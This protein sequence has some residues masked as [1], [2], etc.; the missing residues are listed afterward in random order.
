MPKGH[1]RCPECHG[2][3]G[4]MAMVVGG[5]SRWQRCRCV[6]GGISE[7]S[8]MQSMFKVQEV[9]EQGA[10]RT[11]LKLAIDIAQYCGITEIQM[12]NYLVNHL[13]YKVY[14]DGNISALIH[15]MYKENEN[16]GQPVAKG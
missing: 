4:K 14:T 7:D 9:I 6:K 10:D 16:N 5:K 15:D 8:K 12:V 11:K 3:G 1:P 13:T 2:A